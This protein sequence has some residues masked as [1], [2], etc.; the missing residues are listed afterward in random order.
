M[1]H[2]NKLLPVVLLLLSAISLTAGSRFFVF[3]I[4]ASSANTG[5]YRF[6]I[7]T[8]HSPEDDALEFTRFFNRTAGRNLFPPDRDEGSFPLESGALAHWRKET[9]N[10]PDNDFDF[11]RSSKS[12]SIRLTFKGQAKT[13]QNAIRL[14]YQHRLEADGKVSELAGIALLQP[15]VPALIGGIAD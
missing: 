15:K 8:V 10:L 3:R 11:T 7:I 9:F 4:G 13:V 1:K 2:P 14:K 6:E 5:M 12:P